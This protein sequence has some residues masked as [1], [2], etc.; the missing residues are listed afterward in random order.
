MASGVVKRVSTTGGSN[1][2]QFADG[3]MIIWG[4]GNVDLTV[5]AN[6]TGIKAVG[7]PKDFI[8]TNYDFIVNAINTSIPV[9]RQASALYSGKN[10]HWINIQYQNNYAVDWQPSISWIAIGKWK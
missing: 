6:S 4:S 10:T 5:S 9:L 2:V 8:D 3:T 1:Y 7:F